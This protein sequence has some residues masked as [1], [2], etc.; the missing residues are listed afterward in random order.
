MH[1]IKSLHYKNHITHANG[2]HGN[3]HALHEAQLQTGSALNRGFKNAAA[4]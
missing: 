1:T 3:A 4:L 2:T